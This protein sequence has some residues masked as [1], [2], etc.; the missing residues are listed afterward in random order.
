MAAGRN[1]AEQ[2]SPEQMVAR[3][4]PSIERA[5]AERS[6]A[7]DQRR[8][9]FPFMAEMTD[10]FREAG[11]DPRPVYARNEKGKEWGTNPDGPVRP[12][13][14]RLHTTHG[15][16]QRVVEMAQKWPNKPTDY[17]ARMQ[18]AIKPNAWRVEE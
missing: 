4:A 11:M 18:R 10:L 14:N 17:R 2:L 7:R 13:D 3:L 5:A 12:V 8:A 15:Y 1:R 16:E 6:A 9:D